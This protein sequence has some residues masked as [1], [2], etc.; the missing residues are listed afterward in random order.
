MRLVLQL[1]AR[2]L[3]VV[4]FCLGAATVWA[5][6]DAYRSVDRATAASAQ[7]VSQALNDRGLS[8]RQA[9]EASNEAA[10]PIL[11]KSYN[12]MRLRGYVNR[13]EKQF[14]E[15]ID[16]RLPSTPSAT[17]TKATLAPSWSEFRPSGGPTFCGGASA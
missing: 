3:V 4:V 9:L 10:G 11:S 17:A 16:V 15:I 12:R 7:R 6:L 2:L 1:I 5:T 8:P 14:A 13:L